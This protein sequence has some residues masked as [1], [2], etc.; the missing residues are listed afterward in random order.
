MLF[1]LPAHAYIDPG[2]GSIVLQMILAAIAGGVF[3]FRNAVARFFS[4]FRKSDTAD[5]AANGESPPE[6]ENRRS[7]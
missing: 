7:S 5:K 2:T 3:F 6:S 1:P 4:L